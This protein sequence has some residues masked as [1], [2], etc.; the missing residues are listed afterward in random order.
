M[1]VMTVVLWVVRKNLWLGMQSVEWREMRM[2]G[3]W[4]PWLA[5]KKA[6]LKAGS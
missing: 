6:A 4:G 1:V 3:M 2:A 5:Q